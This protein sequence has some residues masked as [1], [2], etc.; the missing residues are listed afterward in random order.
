MAALFILALALAAGFRLACRHLNRLMSGEP[1]NHILIRSF[2]YWDSRKR[3]RTP[4]SN[5]RPTLGELQRSYP[6]CW[7]SCD[8]CQHYTPVAYAPFVIRWGADASSDLL[9][10]RARCT[11]CGHK[12]ASLQ[13]PSWMNGH[14]G[15]A[16]FPIKPLCDESG[17]QVAAK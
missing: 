4:R 17:L 2:A 6:W 13:H 12:G 11:A 10:Q 15:F 16:M 14:V 8:R 3:N 1:P 9:R 7:L 5:K